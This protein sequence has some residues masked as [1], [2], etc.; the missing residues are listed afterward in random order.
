MP[1]ARITSPQAVLV[2]T[3][4]SLWERTMPASERLTIWSAWLKSMRSG[5][6]WVPTVDEFNHTRARCAASTGA[7]PARSVGQFGSHAPVAGRIE[8]APRQR[9]ILNRHAM[10]LE[11][12]D[13]MHVGA[14]R[15][16]PGDHLSQLHQ[17]AL[18]QPALLQRR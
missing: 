1:S 15:A 3:A 10:R 8:H 7:G 17:L 14:A 16:Q 18:V 5:T 13:P 11:Q 9:Q 2:N 4:S 6:I 12:R